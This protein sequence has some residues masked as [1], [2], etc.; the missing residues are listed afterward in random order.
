MVDF[1]LHAFNLLVLIGVCSP[2]C[3]LN[4]SEIEC[5]EQE[6]SELLGI[7]SDDRF[8]LVAHDTNEDVE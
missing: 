7:A 1:M 6:I 2:G 3:A 5:L 8:L 4:V